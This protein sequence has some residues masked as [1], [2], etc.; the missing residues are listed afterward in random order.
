MT[1]SSDF[2]AL[3]THNAQRARE[4]PLNEGAAERWRMPP[5]DWQRHLEAK[6]RLYGRAGDTAKELEDRG[7]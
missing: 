2:Y 6:A 5:E 1:A 4:V 7:S 3:A